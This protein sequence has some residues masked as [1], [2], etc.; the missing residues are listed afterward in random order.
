MK[1]TTPKQLLPLIAHTE[2]VEAEDITAKQIPLPYGA[3]FYCSR[4][5]LT[6]RLSGYQQAARANPRGLHAYE[7]RGIRRVAFA[8]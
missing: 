8:D 2:V 5:L 4:D 7:Q 3:V 6:I 1:D